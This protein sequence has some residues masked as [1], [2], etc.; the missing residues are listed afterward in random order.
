MLFKALTITKVKVKITILKLNFNCYEKHILTHLSLVIR[1]VLA[2]IVFTHYNSPFTVYIRH[3]YHKMH[4]G[5]NIGYTG[6]VYIYIYT[7]TLS[8]S[9]LSLYIYILI[10]I[11][12]PVNTSK[13]KNLKQVAFVNHCIRQSWIAL[14][15]F[16]LKKI[17]I[18]FHL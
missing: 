17:F 2:Y 9:S 10:S 15:I 6:C 3:R 18:M 1:T 16:C 11:F 5:Y 8:L 13:Q 7:Y 14:I 12:F 4:I